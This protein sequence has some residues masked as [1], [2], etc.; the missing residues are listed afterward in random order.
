MLHGIL[1]ISMS[2]T[3]ALLATTEIFLGIREPSPDNFLAEIR[4]SMKSSCAVDKL[5]AMA[6]I[7]CSLAAYD[8]VAE[9]LYSLCRTELTPTATLALQTRDTAGKLVSHITL[10]D[11][12]IAG[13]HWDFASTDKSGGL[14]MFN[15]AQR[16]SVVRL[17][18]TTGAAKH[19]ADIPRNLSASWLMPTTVFDEEAQLL[20]QVVMP[21]SVGH[22]QAGTIMSS[23]ELDSLRRTHELAAGRARAP[24]SGLALLKINLATGRSSIVNLT[25]PVF[26]LDDGLWNNAVLVPGKSQVAILHN[27]SLVKIDVTSGKVEVLCPAC[28]ALQGQLPINA[29]ASLDGVAYVRMDPK[30]DSQTLKPLGDPIVYGMSLTNGEVQNRCTL[31]ESFAYGQVL[32]AAPLSA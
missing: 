32:L 11:P 2:M 14:I 20:T 19:L 24:S 9:R 21:L 30:M 16:G 10:N 5:A 1:A 17:D 31:N 12:M 23:H 4:P 6:T 7:N 27:T 29:I 28:S 22:P 26:T 25:A 8:S 13:Q 18:L 15:A 3:S